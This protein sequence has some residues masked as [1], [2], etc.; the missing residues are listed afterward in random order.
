MGGSRQ[1]V[2]GKRF[3]AKGSG[4]KVQVTSGSVLYRL[5]FVLRL[6]PEIIDFNRDW[7]VVKSVLWYKVKFIFVKN[8]HAYRHDW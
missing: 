8:T 6:E 7:L 2:Q 5:P 1:K 4:Q 3:R